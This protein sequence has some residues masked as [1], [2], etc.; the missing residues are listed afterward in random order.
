LLLF[1][2]FSTLNAPLCTLR[3]INSHLKSLNLNTF[4]FSTELVSLQGGESTKRPS[5][6]RLS[7]FGYSGTIAHGSFCAGRP[8]ESN[9]CGSSVSLYHVRSTRGEVSVSL[10]RRIALSRDR[11]QHSHQM[12][13][14]SP[15]AAFC[16]VLT[17]AKSRATNLFTST[18]NT[19]S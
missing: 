16:K 4:Y 9:E 7:S 12:T 10:I 8:G 14:D 13:S 19:Q 1:P 17:C 11:R 2:L 18:W 6:G 3:S 5:C 15:Y